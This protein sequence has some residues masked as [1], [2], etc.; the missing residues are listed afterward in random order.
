MCRALQ[1][2]TLSERLPWCAVLAHTVDATESA[3]DR[4]AL[5]R[6]NK[7]GRVTYLNAVTE[8]IHI[9]ADGRPLPRKHRET[10]AWPCK[11]RMDSLV[12]VAP[13]RLLARAYFGA[14]RHRLLWRARAGGQAVAVQAVLPRLV[15]ALAQVTDEGLLCRCGGLQGAQLIRSS[16]AAAMQ[17]SLMVQDQ[18]SAIYKCMWAGAASSR[19]PCY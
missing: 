19:W 18:K 11:D 15:P 1:T 10:D 14:R 12:M 2:G 16:C 17:R 9:E 6:C 7:H 13:Q 8:G 3:Q 5:A 4:S